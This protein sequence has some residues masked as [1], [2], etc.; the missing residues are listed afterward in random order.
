M[1]EQNTIQNKVANIIP[2]LY[3]K[4]ECYKIIGAAF[5][6]HKIL[7]AG[8]LESVYQEAFETELS[9]R[10]IPFI[11]QP[12][13]KINYKDHLL[14]KTFKADLLI[15]DKI[16]VE[17]KAINSLTKI[18]DAQVI[19]YLKATKLNLGILINFGTPKMEWKRLV[20]T[21]NNH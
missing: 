16:I 10:D 15:Y 17:I 19:N 20:C 2:D 7:G 6:T 9:N 8:F 12:E 21:H 13:L 18:E 11:S 14:T 3:L 5:E 1:T 4:E